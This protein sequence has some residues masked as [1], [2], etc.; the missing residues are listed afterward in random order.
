[1]LGMMQ[2]AAKKRSKERQHGQKTQE[3]LEP[4]RLADFSFHSNGTCS[5][6]TASLQAAH[7][8]GVF[9]YSFPGSF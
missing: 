1:M 7:S 6:R 3:L 8:F 5:T 2:D 9:G 4:T